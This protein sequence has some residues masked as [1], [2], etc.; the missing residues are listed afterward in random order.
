M[1]NVATAE[2]DPLSID[3]STVKFTAE[4]F[5]R[6]CEA[7]PDRAFELTAQG[8]LVVMPIVNI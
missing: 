3:L 5:E 4:Q 8:V 6:V 7:N 1:T 2:L